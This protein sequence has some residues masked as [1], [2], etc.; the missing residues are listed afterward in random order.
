MKKIVGL[1]LIVSAFSFIRCTK[2]AEDCEKNNYGV[3]SVSY[4]LS[5]SRHSILFTPMGSLNSKDK[6]TAIGVT[7]DTVHIKPGTY[8]VEIASIDAGGLA[9]DSQSGTVLIEQCGETTKTVTF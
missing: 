8:N 1:I 9:I 6:I 7:S 3:L 4:G 2:S 5:S